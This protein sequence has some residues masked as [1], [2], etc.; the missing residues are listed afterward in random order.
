MEQWIDISATGEVARQ[1]VCGC[2][3]VLIY[4]SGASSLEWTMQVSG[5]K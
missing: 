2:Y 4:V 5:A 1:Q 3:R